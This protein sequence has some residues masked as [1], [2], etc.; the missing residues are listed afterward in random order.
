MRCVYLKLINSNKKQKGPEKKEKPKYRRAKFQY[1]GKETK[2]ITKLFKNSNLKV[3]FK[4]DSTIGKLLT[5]NK[6][7]SSNKFSKCSTY[8][9][10]CQDCNKN[11]AR[12]GRPSH[13]R[14][15]EHFLD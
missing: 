2:F 15:Q 10:T 8:Q 14:F 5:S 7:C 12:I 4:T 3:S 9:L 6:E 13:T 1:I 11:I